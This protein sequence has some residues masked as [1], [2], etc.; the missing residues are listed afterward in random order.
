MQIEISASYMITASVLK[1]LKKTVIR[2]E[3][4][5][6]NMVIWICCVRPEDKISVE[7]RIRPQFITM[8]EYLQ[9]RKLIWLGNLERFEENSWP[10]KCWK[11][12]VG[13][14]LARRWQSSETK[15]GR[16]KSQ[17]LARQKTQMCESHL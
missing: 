11:F 17:Q 12:Q 4:N 7:I 15:S 10:C 1:E 5:D 16:M 8:R 3:R 9:K 14:S 13:G 6:A 2:L